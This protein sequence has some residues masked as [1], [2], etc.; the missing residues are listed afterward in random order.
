MFRL[1]PFRET[2]ARQM[3][4]YDGFGEGLFELVVFLLVI[5]GTIIVAIVGITFGIA[6]LCAFG[7]SWSWA[8]G[9]PNAT[10]MADSSGPSAIVN[11]TWASGN[12]NATMDKSDAQDDRDELQAPERRHAV[13]RAVTLGASLAI[14]VATFYVVLTCVSVI[15]AATDLSA[16]EDAARVKLLSAVE[17]ASTA[18]ELADLLATDEQSVRHRIAVHPSVGSTTQQDLVMNASE[19][20]RV[21]MT[22]DAKRLWPE[23]A[24]ILAQDKSDD[25]R[26]AF[27]GRADADPALLVPLLYDESHDV[28]I[29]AFKN[30]RTPRLE[31]CSI[32]QEILEGSDRYDHYV[33]EIGEMVDYCQSVRMSLEGADAASPS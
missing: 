16:I 9:N 27:A 21:K 29:A 15:K 32:V 12:P 17:D 24:S 33:Q 23:S 10:R 3:M 2:L 26:E 20:M 7:E 18:A 5:V 22:T 4:S 31:K 14:L 8:R 19:S 6:G 1:V 30:P 11:W 13:K 28:G 25:V